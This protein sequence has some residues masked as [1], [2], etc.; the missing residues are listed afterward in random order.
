MICAIFS[1]KCLAFKID[2]LGINKLFSSILEA[3]VF[4]D[5]T[6]YVGTS[7]GRALVFWT[8]VLSQISLP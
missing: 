5:L 7:S 3:A 8:Q 4:D 6:D 2:V 1:V